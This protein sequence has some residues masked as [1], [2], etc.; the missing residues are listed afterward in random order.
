MEEGKLSHFEPLEQ[1]CVS[2]PRCCMSHI[3][4]GRTTF[5]F[6][7][8]TLFITLYLHILAQEMQRECKSFMLSLSVT[9]HPNQLLPWV[10]H[11]SLAKISPPWLFLSLLPQVML[12]VYII[13]GTVTSSSPI[14]AP[15]SQPG[16]TMASKAIWFAFHPVARQHRVMWFLKTPW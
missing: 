12:S 10:F 15:V 8:S 3:K 2:K 1:A 9:P 13:Q 6:S 4:Y 14:V 11:L 16:L 7:P 5:G